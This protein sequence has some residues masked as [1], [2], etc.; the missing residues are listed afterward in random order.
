MMYYSPY[1]TQKAYAKQRNIEWHFT[2]DIWIQWWGDDI[3]N[4]GP[5][6]GQLCMARFGDTGPYHPDNVRKATCAENQNEAHRG[7]KRSDET[8][9]KMRIAHLGI[10]RGS[11]NKNKESV[12]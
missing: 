12:A 2:Y 1:H 7:R 11:Y 6:K 5:R 9:E 4:R 8:K 3:I 10:K